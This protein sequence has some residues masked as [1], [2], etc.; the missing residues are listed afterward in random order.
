MTDYL[1]NLEQQEEIFPSPEETPMVEQTGEDAP[2]EQEKEETPT[3]E[4]EQE[5][6]SGEPE[7]KVKR[8]T[9][10]RKAET[11]EEE[12]PVEPHSAEPEGID[13]IPLEKETSAL[14]EAEQRGRSNRMKRMLQGVPAGR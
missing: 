4:Q 9:R 2:I 7:E 3:V 6:A 13:T 12:I 8:R 10:R 1:E 11:T 5:D 14:Q